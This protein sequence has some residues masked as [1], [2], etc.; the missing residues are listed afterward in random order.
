M[1][2]AERDLNEY[3]VRCVLKL[4]NNLFGLKT[5]K[6]L[7]LLESALG[8]CWSISVDKEN[9]YYFWDIVGI[10]CDCFLALTFE[11]LTVYTLLQ[12]CLAL[13]R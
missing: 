9:E 13:N 10:Y 12:N 4:E 8:W 5:G 11:Y 3:I 7:P 2:N 1:K 6:L